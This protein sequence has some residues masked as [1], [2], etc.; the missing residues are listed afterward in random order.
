MGLNFSSYKEGIVIIENTYISPENILIIQATRK[1]R[2][3]NEFKKYIRD[4]NK[5]SVYFKHIINT[6]SFESNDGFIRKTKLISNMFYI[7]Y[8]IDIYENVNN[9]FL[10]D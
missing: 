10:Y 8:E 6:I 4:T 2:V 5:Q 9:Y 1:L 7:I 3:L